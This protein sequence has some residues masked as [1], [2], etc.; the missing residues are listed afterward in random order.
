MDDADTLR[1]EYARS[2]LAEGAT[3][4]SASIEPVGDRCVVAH[5]SDGR[6]LA[7]NDEFAFLYASKDAFDERVSI[8]SAHIEMPP[9]A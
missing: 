7:V 4:L 5:L 3:V 2:L 8:P 1:L 6:V 9:R